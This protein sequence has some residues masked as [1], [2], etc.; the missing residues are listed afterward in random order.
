MIL[1][2]GLD[3]WG[4]PRRELVWELGTLRYQAEELALVLAPD[5]VSLLPLSEAGR[6]DLELSLTGVSTG[7]HPMVF[8]RDWLDENGVLGSLELEACDSGRRVRIA[9]RVIM[10]QA[11]P[12]ANGFSFLTLEDEDGMMNVVARPSVYER[13]RRV[14][15]GAALLLVEGVVQREGAV[16]NLLAERFAGFA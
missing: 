15:R 4:I 10:H 1:A 2:S 8:Y 5:E 12:T 14:V 16:V 3:G 11:P 7:V 6:L 13:W 9:G